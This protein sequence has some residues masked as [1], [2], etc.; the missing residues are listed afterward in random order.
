MKIFKKETILVEPYTIESFVFSR[1]VNNEELC[2]FAFI[3]SDKKKILVD[4]QILEISCP[5]FEAMLEAEMEETKLNEAKVDDVDSD[6]MMELLRFLYCKRVE[7]IENFDDKLLF[8]AN[9]YGVD[10]L[11]PICVKSLSENLDIENV[12]SILTIAH[13]LNLANLKVACFDFI[14]W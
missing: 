5:A 14:K 11:I 2:N 13:M 4:K 12:G 10:D 7:N 1:M 9:K 8:A 3:C 6:A